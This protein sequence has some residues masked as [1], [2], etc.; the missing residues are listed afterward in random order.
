[1]SQTAIRAT[2]LTKRFKSGRN[3]I[4]VLKGVDFDAQLGDLTMVMGPSGSGKSTLVA[5]LSGL[6]RPDEGKVTAL[7]RDLWGMKSGQIDRFRLENAAS[8]SRASTFSRP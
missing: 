4:E 1:M 2:G 3:Q 6:L 8:S 7:D 5:A